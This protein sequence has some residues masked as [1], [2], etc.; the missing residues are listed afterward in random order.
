MTL[1]GPWQISVGRATEP[2]GKRIDFN[3]GVG[4]RHAG[5]WTSRVA[6]DATP[7]LRP[8]RRLQPLAIPII[9]TFCQRPIPVTTL[10]WDQSAIDCAPEGRPAV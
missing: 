3:F 8:T 10:S 9:S 7:V 1:A 2:I 4:G 6:A 5:Q